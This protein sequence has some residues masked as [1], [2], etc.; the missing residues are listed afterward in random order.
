MGQTGSR[1]TDIRRAIR[2]NE[3]SVT[4]VQLDGTRL[5]EKDV[6]KLS[7]ALRQN[8]Y[9]CKKWVDLI[10]G[11]F[12]ACSVVQ[13]LSLEKCSVTPTSV[14]HLAGVL[15]NSVLTCSIRKLSLAN[16]DSVSIIIPANS[17]T[18]SY[19]SI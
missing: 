5:T 15:C 19:I 7:E 11:V 1:G 17:S 18:T 10:A 4:V 12:A 13:S 3:P 9:E 14:Q 2:G 8:R 16:N 6:R